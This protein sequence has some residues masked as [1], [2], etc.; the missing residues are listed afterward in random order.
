MHEIAKVLEHIHS[1][2]IL[3]RDLKPD[4]V[5]LLSEHARKDGHWIKLI[6]FGVSLPP[7][8][9]EEKGNV[10]PGTSAYMSPEQIRGIRID[11]RSDIYSYGML[12]YE[13]LTG[14]LP[15]EGVSEAKL[16]EFQLVG[17][18]PDPVPL[19]AGLS[20]TIKNLPLICLEKRPKDRLQNM[21]EVIAWLERGMEKFE[22]K[23]KR[24]AE[25]GIFRFWYRLIGKEEKNEKDSAC[26]QN[27]Q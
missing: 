27:G 16:L 11:Q 23:M 13:L 24:K 18:I 6:D 7:D 21:Q 19:Y 12:T 1:K 8:E 5:L 17:S 3:Y 14:K 26:P 4:N 22:K 2:N 25:G 10:M 20:W 15:Y 9:Q